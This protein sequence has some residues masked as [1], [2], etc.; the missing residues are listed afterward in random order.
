MAYGPNLGSRDRLQIVRLSTIVKIGILY[1]SQAIQ[2]DALIT[3]ILVSPVEHGF[4]SPAGHREH[5]SLAAHRLRTPDA[6]CLISEQAK[7]AP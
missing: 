4:A 2:R 5:S 3:H 7:E 1:W 6:Q